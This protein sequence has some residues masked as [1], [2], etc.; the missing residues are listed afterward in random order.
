VTLATAP[1][2]YSKITRFI[3]TPKILGTYDEGV[4]RPWYQ[5]VI[6]WYGVI[7]VIWFYLYWRFW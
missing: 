5:R 7:S 1:P 4:R 2:D 6:F 3:W